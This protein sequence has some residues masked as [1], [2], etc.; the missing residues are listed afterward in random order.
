MIINYKVGI[1]VSDVLVVGG[2]TVNN[3]C[4]PDIKHGSFLLSL[5]MVLASDY[6][7]GN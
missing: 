3:N 2:N 5:H 7:E 1:F 4:H 6:Y